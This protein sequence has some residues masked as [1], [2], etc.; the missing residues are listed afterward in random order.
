MPCP[1]QAYKQEVVGPQVSNR[2]LESPQNSSMETL[3]ISS[4]DVYV[5]SPTLTSRLGVLNGSALL[6]KASRSSDSSNI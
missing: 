4:L 5:Y 3:T 1:G 6:L 2:L